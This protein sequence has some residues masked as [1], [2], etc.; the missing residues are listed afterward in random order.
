MSEWIRQLDPQITSS[1]DWPTR[2]SHTAWLRFASGAGR[3]RRRQWRRRIERLDDVNWFGAVPPQGAWLRVT[4]G[5]NGEA[6]LWSTGYD[7]LGS[8]EIRLN[9]A[10][11]GVLHARRL[12]D[13]VGIEL[14][15]R[16]PDDLLSEEQ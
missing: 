4:D 14:R 10:R 12:S 6:Q 16:G 2:A 9:P 5:T 3:P 1:R 15:Y 7:R 11:E 8:I 13:G